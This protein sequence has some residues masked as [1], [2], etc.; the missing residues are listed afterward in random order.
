MFDC[1]LKLILRFF[2][3]FWDFLGFLAINQN[4]DTQLSMH[5][6][7]HHCHMNYLKLDYSIFIT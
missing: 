4:I 7:N 1:P 2:G 3:I 6:K 5:M